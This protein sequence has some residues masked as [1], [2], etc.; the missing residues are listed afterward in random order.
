M[1]LSGRKL[2]A[3]NSIAESAHARSSSESLLPI[4]RLPMPVSDGQHLDYG[5]KFSIDHRKG[6]STQQKSSR[7]VNTKGP[8][9]G[10]FG[11]FGNGA[12]KLIGKAGSY[13]L[14]PF[15]VPLEGGFKF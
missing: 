2:K 13:G 14:A 12:V 9:L 5:R 4:S 11:N 7:S 3:K 8:A 1:H 15:K 10:R 6:K